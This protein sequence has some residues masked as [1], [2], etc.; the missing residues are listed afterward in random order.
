MKMKA[1]SFFSD[2]ERRMIREAVEEAEKTTMGEVAIMVVDESDRYRE[3]ELSGALFF[4]SLLALVAALALHHITIWF[5]IPA[6]A[7]LFGPFFL[8]FRQFPFLKLA[9]LGHS[10]IAEAVRQRAVLCFFQ[11]GVHRTEEQTGILLF[12]SL[13][14]RKVWILGDTGI[15]A[16]I[17]AEVWSSLASELSEG[18]RKGRAPE[19]LRQVIAKCGKELERHFPGRSGQKNELCDDVIC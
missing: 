14:E 8:L 15:D 5:F 16:K 13:L 2:D 9:F 19:T 7:I 6:T 10:R 18:I 3:A 17:G 1:K 11:R 12:I 4:S